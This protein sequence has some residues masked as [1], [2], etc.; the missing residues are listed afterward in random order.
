MCLGFITARLSELPEV[1]HER[2]TV[3]NS[4][5][6]VRPLPEMQGLGRQAARAPVQRTQAQP[7]S[8]SGLP[9]V[10]TSPRPEVPLEALPGEAR[11]EELQRRHGHLDHRSKFESTF[12]SG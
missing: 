8:A 2:R 3:A 12:G 9:A 5:F 11:R 10:Q 6:G 1:V 7:R 4:H